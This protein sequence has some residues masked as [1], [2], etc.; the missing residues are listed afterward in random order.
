[1][2]IE[3]LPRGTKC[4]FLKITWWKGR[5]IQQD[6]YGWE[7]IAALGNPLYQLLDG[8]F[9]RA[10]LEKLDIPCL[11]NAKIL[12]SERHKVLFQ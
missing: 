7:E 9:T 3:A 6:T 1:M 2:S 8:L 12:I 10:N 4:P 5:S 11:W